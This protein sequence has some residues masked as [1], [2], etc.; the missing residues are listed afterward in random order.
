MCKNLGLVQENQYHIDVISALKNFADSNEI[1]V[2]NHFEDVVDVVCRKQF[3]VKFNALDSNLK[4]KIP[5][6]VFLEQDSKDWA[7]ILECVN[8]PVIVKP[9][10]SS[11][12]SHSHDLF[13]VRDFESL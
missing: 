13:I 10:V 2:Y 1:F 9:R 11:I 6:S 7:K 3:I 8:F 5:N 4:I 12:V